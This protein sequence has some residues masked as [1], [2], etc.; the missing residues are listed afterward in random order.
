MLRVDFAM[1]AATLHPDRPAHQ[2]KSGRWY[3]GV[4]HIF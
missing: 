1:P 2:L 3:F 4:G